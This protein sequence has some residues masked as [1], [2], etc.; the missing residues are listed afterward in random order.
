[1]NNIRLRLYMWG[2]LVCF[3]TGIHGQ[4]PQFSQFYNSSLYYNPATA[5]I[6]Q[7]LRFSSSY[8]NLWSNIPGDLSTYFF[9]VDYQLTKK[10]MGLGFLM[11]GDNE[12][13]NNQSTQR[14]ELIYSYR[15]QSKNK[16]LQFGMT[17]FS[18]NIRDLKDKNFVFTD[19]LDA[20]HG[21]VQQSAFI[22]DNLEPKVYPDWNVGMV[23]KQNFV[24]KKITPTIGFSA[25]HIFRPNISY[26]SN[27]FRLP[28]K[29]VFH[30]NVLTQIAFHKDNVLNR[31]FA[32]LSPGFVYE[33]QKPFQT[34]TLG[35]GFDVY[36][37]RT[38]IWFRN[39]SVVSDVYKYNSVVVL[40]GVVIPI[41][42]NHNLMI[43]YT[44]DS[45]ISRLEFASGGAHEITLIYNISLPEKKRSVPCYHEWWRA[46]RGIVHYPKQMMQ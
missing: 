35:T 38:G 19:Q 31:K 45:T 40:V 41:S 18:L 6:T 3:S 46:R 1:M 44:Y 22:H 16:L 14:F 32:F 9:S 42:L 39:R 10:N 4:D 5:G 7:D 43:D 33:Y 25:S 28:V 12:G 34:F 30:T 27:K 8:R 13:L 15:I 24:R 20:I 23:Y 36:P 11:L 17:V 21:V 29:Y 26:M 37:L 2:M